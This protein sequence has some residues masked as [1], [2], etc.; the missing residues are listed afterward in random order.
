MSIDRVPKVPFA[1]IANSALRDKRLSFK[2]R[3]VLAMVLSHSGEWSATRDFIVSMSDNDGKDAVQS[4]LNELTKHG[5]RT[6]VRNQKEDGTWDSYV[7]W[8]HHPEDTDRRVFRRPVDPATTRT[9]LKNKEQSD[10][11]DGQSSSN[12]VSQIP[13]CPYCR[14]LMKGKGHYCSAMNVY[15]NHPRD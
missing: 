1:Q 7:Q 12:T 9:P 3:G 2:A 11:P 14:D 8:T 4:A 6:V 5:Y 10:S 13:R 15:M